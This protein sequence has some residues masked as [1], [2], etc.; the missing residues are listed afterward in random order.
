MIHFPHHSIKKTLWSS[1]LVVGFVLIGFLV[2]LIYANFLVYTKATPY[3]YETDEAFSRVADAVLILWAKVYTDGRLSRAVQDRADVAIALRKK[4][5]VKKILISGDNRT[6]RYDEVT[7]IK[8]YV[9]DQGVPKQDVFL[10]YAWLD[11]YDSVYRAQYIFG[12]TS[13]LI[14][15]Q[16]FHVYRAVYLARELDIDAY[17]IIANA[18]PLP[19]VYKLSFREFFARGKARWDILFWSLPR[20]LWEKVPFDSES[21]S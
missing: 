16:S 1:F 21:N 4:G 10:D 9:F 14:P 11:T 2:L 5:K 18:H 7:T 12:A 8:N 19:S 13:L 6:R 3:V 15:T 17:G 20:H